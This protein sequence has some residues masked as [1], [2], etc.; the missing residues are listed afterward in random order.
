LGNK[1]CAIEKSIKL[2][3]KKVRKFIVLSLLIMVASWF[4]GE[5]LPGSQSIYLG[6]GVKE[7]GLGYTG[8]SGL[9]SIDGITFNPASQ[10]DARRMANSFTFGGIGSRTAVGLL[11][12]SLPFDFGV[13][14]FNALYSG[15]GGENAL[16]SLYGGVFSIAKPITENLFWGTSLKFLYGNSRTSDWA[17]AIDMGVI[18]KEE[19]GTKGFGL[20][21]YSYGLVIRNIGKIINITNYDP[22]PPMTLGLGGSFYPLIFD[23]YRL[24]LIADVNIPFYPLGF[25][26]NVG[27]ENIFFDFIKVRGGYILSFPEGSSF[28]EVGPFTFGVSLLG[29]FKISQKEGKQDFEFKFG[30]EKLEDSTDIEISYCLQQQKFNGVG[31]IAHFVG[32]DIAW[33]YYDDQKPDVGMSVETNYIS[34]NFDGLQDV[35]RIYPRMKDNKFVDGWQLD[36]VDQ[37]GKTV[38]TYNSI[39]KLKIRSLDFMKFVKQIFSVKQ[40]VEIPEYI[41]WNGQDKDGK[42]VSDGEYF[43]VLTAWDENKNTAKSEKLSIFVDTVVPEVKASLP[44]LIFS[45]NNDNSKDELVINLSSK[46]IMPNDKVIVSI[47]D[48]NNVEV[49]NFTFDSSC[50]DKVN[51]D[52]KDNNGKP[53]PE[54]EYSVNVSAVDFAGNKT[55]NPTFKVTLVTNYQVATLATSL[56]KFSPNNDG[57]KDSI[58]FYPKV[59]DEKGLEKWAL[60]IF[61][62]N[63]KVVKTF[64]GKTFLPKEVYW[65]G[66]G[67]NRQTLPDGDYYCKLELFFDSGNY[68]ASEKKKFTIDTSPPQIFVEPEYLSFSPNGDGKQDTLTFRHKIF[69]DDNDIIEMKILD[70]IG[71][72]IYY[73]RTD[74]KNV[75]GEFVWNG[76]DKNLKP[77]PEG[78]YTYVIEGIDAVG[79]KSKFEVKNIFLKTGLEQ[80]AVQADVVAISPNN[81]EGNKRVVF[82]TSV[83]TKKGILDFK[84]FI[85]KDGKEI[86]TFVTNQYVEKIVWDGRDNK[87]TI[88]PDGVYTYQFKVKYDFGDEPVSTPKQIIIDSVSP[89]IEILTKDYAFSPNGDGRKDNFVIKQKVKGD[90]SDVYKASIVDSKNNVVKTYTFVGNVPEE[91][92]WDGKD[93]KGNELPEGIYRYRVEGVD[94]ANNKTVREIPKIK[95]VRKYENVS[96]S[97]SGKKFSPSLGQKLTLNLDVSSVDDLEEAYVDIYNSE[98]KLVRRISISTNEKKQKVEWDG[99]GEKGANLPDGVYR[100]EINFSY[101]SGNLLTGEVTDILMD[102]TPPE[103]VMNVSPEVFTPDGDGE[104][105]VMYINLNLNDFT[106]VKEWK[107]LIYKRVEKKEDINIFKTFSGKG[108]GKFLIQWDGVSDD[109]EDVVEAVQDYVMELTV[110]DEVGNKKLITNEFTTGVLVEKTPD[111]LRIRVS[112]I[113]FAF[114]SA[115]FVGDYEKPLKK[116][117]YILRKIMSAPEK[118]GLSKN[119]KIEVSG[120]TDDVGAEDYNQKLSERRAKAVYEYLVK[121]D[122]DPAILTY[123]G[124]GKSRPYKIIKAGMSKEKVNEYRARNRRVEFF[125]KK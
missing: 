32:F 121:N 13:L 28:S 6:N 108:K 18:I 38:R 82:T 53:L 64:E 10:A 109:K 96:L 34:P 94:A 81:I 84:F 103:V 85:T 104:D 25:S 69:G 67:D 4:F 61:D 49:K 97:I 29:K 47:L 1:S 111:G 35:A 119:F 112:S 95:L 37:S 41:D 101:A 107:L 2:R 120:H 123:V 30:K 48:K 114:D 40:Q 12:I 113:L 110:L 54:G 24:K 45:P 98:N 75:P 118:Y 76:L 21:D 80:I 65:D 122:I 87:G 83:T 79:N 11:G 14:S 56:D 31:E 90:K 99:L 57:V 9:Y 78:K 33:G 27:V 44:Y 43:A 22:F 16:S 55:I 58:F 46:N 7:A 63:D 19:T 106:D 68:P 20:N 100:A 92:L 72:V 89:E 50:P 86:Y 105:D 59:S 116:I 39:E 125:I 36:I 73:N 62:V 42:V 17:L 88:L 102:A 91:V 51:W 71:N 3:R 93:D 124:Y 70:E 8:I 23:F 74:L 66:K 115:R 117:I 5:S 52:G 26:L 60:K 77:L 15:S